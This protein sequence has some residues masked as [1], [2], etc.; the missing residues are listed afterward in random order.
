MRPVLLSLLLVACLP[1]ILADTAAV[2]DSGDT[3]T[4]DTSDTDTGD[5][6][7]SGDTD[8]GD[9]DSGDTGDSDSA[10]AAA[11]ADAGPDQEVKLGAEVTL[12]ATG[13]SAPDGGALQYQWAIQS[14][15]A[16]SAIA[17]GD[18]HTPDV[19]RPFFTPDAA[20]DYTFSLAVFWNAEWSSPDMVTITVTR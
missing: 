8:T 15:P 11:V 4:G 2:A 17:A 10:A 5:T 1:P 13:S 19:A 18:L 16:G 14:K 6:G 12:D 9:T 20:G 3:D 7:D